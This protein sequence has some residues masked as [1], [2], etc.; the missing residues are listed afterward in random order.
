MNR[1]IAL[2][3]GNL[4][5]GMGAAWW[6]DKHNR[7]HANPNHVGKD[8]DVEVVLYWPVTPWHRRKVTVGG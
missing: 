6:S 2:F 3:H 7:H 4:L 8:P 1:A 5:L